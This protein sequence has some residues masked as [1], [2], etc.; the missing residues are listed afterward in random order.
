[1]ATSNAIADFGRRPLQFKV[2]V[3][4]GIGAVLALMYYQFSYSKI[5]SDIKAAEE[6]HDALLNDK[7]KLAQEE[8]EYAQLKKRQDVLDAIIK[9]ND[10]A[11]PTAAQLPAFFDMLN[12]KVGEAGVEVRRWDY[13]KEAQVE[14][15]IY[16]VPVEIEMTGTFYQIKRFFFLLAKLNRD[17]ADKTAPADATDAADVEERD[18]ILTI[19][20][21]KLQKPEVR[22]GDLVMTVTFRAS[23]FRKEVPPEPEPDPKKKAKDDKADAKD[24]K[25]DAKA[26]P[27]N[28]VQKAKADT[29]KALEKSD[30]R[31]RKAGGDDS[32]VDKVKGGM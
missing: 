32:P 16:K 1:M 8:A 26:A 27:K 22:N 20:E 23:T 4:V 30:D 25:S 12:R 18:R 14:E 31:A 13:L 24:P 28:P 11:L 19:E 6:T 17:N 7:T 29:E 3:F 9:E 21:L 5:R 15:T 10:A 2:A